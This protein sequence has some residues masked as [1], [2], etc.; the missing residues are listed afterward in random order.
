MGDEVLAYV[1]LTSFRE[2]RCRLCEV[3]VKGCDV[4]SAKL[5]LTSKLSVTKCRLRLGVS[6]LLIWATRCLLSEG[7]ISE[8]DEVLAY[9][10]VT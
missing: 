2:M 1:K 3:E 7:D 9:V 6:C 10:K 4:V 8:A 5:E